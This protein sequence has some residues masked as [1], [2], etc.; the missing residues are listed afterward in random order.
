MDNYVLFQ[1]YGST[2]ILHEAIY[3]ILSLHRF[4]A[5]AKYKIVI[6]TDNKALFLK[7][8][9]EIPIIYEHID[10]D[11]IKNWRGD[12]KFVHRFKIK[13]IADFFEKYQGNLLYVDTDVV[14]KAPIMPI[15]DKISAGQLFM[16]L[17]EGIIEQ[18]KG[19]LGKKLTRFLKKNPQIGV[20]S[21]TM[22]WNAG[23]IG[24]NSSKHKTLIPQVLTISD[25]LYH[26]YQKHVMEQLA[27][28]YCLQNH[29]TVKPLAAEIY[30]YWFF[31]EFRIVLADFFAH[32]EGKAIAELITLIDSI[33]PEVLVLPKKQYEAMPK[34]QRWWWKLSGKTWQN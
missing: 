34:W 31:K 21:S 9:A 20:T 33:N 15:F 22:M 10:S 11:K 19:M 14:F 28:S 23:V 2:A 13:M 27:F 25:A 32:N 30:H 18:Q 4:S 29:S 26:G 7:Y 12:K 3:A 17:A 6:Y 5:H 8:L 16:H 1:A 24:L